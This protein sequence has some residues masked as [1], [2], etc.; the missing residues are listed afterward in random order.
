MKLKVY[1]VLDNKAMAFLP[2]FFMVND[3][4]A[5]R[6]FN[7]SARN[8]DHSFFRNPSDYVLFYIADFDDSSGVIEPLD[9]LVNLGFP[10]NSFEG[11]E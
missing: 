2:P 4:V 6:A 7:D 3:Q 11:G 8:P 5:L 1:A 9:K 10:V